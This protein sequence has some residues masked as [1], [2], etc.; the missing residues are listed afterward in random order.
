MK[1]ASDAAWLVEILG[2]VGTIAMVPTVMLGF[3]DTAMVNGSFCGGT[4]VVVLVP[5]D[6]VA[7]ATGAGACPGGGI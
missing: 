3:G 5:V 6:V 4:A 2:V 1:A 7:D